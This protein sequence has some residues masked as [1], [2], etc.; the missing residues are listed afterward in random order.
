MTTLVNIEA[1]PRAAVIESDEQAIAIAHELA[2]QFV[3]ED[4]E[5]D[6]QK[7]LPVEEVKKFSQSGLWG[8]TVPREYGGAFVSNVTLAE[9]VK[10]ISEADP[11][12]GQIPQ[13][14]L[15]MVEAIRLD[16]TEAQKRFFFDLVLQ[17]QRFGNAFSEIGTKSVT[18]VRTRLERSGDEYVLNGRKFYSAGA[19][20]A[21]WI[22]V[23]ASNDDGKTVIAFV[24]RGAEGLT[25]LDDWTSFGQRTTASGTTILENVKVKP[26]HVISHYLAFERATPM[27]AVAQIIQ[28]A[29]DVGIAKAAVRDTIYFVRNHTRPWV[30]SNLEHG[31]ED[32]LSIYNLGQVQI[33]VHAAEALLRRAGEFI[34]RANESGL[35]EAKV[36]EASI[37]VAEVKALATEVSLLATN[38]LFELAG[39]KSTLQEYNYDRHWRNARA[40]TLH[41]PVRWKY[42]AVGNYFLNGVNPP[43]HP[44]L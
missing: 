17:G 4:S 11:S 10:I 2:A 32:P 31:Y 3:R 5:R 16:G 33:Q 1:E 26:E 8:I 19:L 14:H 9:V 28:A 21:H 15:Y 41:D 44:W 43:R 29:V 30:D 34:D 36:V 18:D 20:L 24:E 39:T 37:A 6:R 38:K 40:H 23:I 25:L 22:P 42:Y 12:L 13:N 7:R 27:G 35:A